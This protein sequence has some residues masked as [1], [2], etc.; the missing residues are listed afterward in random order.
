MRYTTLLYSF[1]YKLPWEKLKSE[2]EKH[3][4]LV[5]QS[6]F[7]RADKMRPRKWSTATVGYQNSLHAISPHIACLIVSCVCVCKTAGR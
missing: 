5:A 4:R 2:K 7:G 3:L 1:R 6:V